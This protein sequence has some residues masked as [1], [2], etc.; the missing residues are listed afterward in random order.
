MASD[1]DALGIDRHRDP[2]DYEVTFFV[3]YDPRERVVFRV[4]AP[5]GVTRDETVRDRLTRQ[6]LRDVAATRGPPAAVAKADALARISRGETAAIRERFE[7]QFEA[8]SLRT[9][10]DVR[11]IEEE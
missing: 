4:E 9:Y 1:G 11:W 8:D 3:V 2:A 6:V 7:E 10:D 5:Y